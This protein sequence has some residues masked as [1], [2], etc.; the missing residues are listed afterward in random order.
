MNPSVFTGSKVEEDPHI[1]IYLI[2][3]ILKAMHATEIEGVDL[4]S[5]QLNDVVNIWF[6]LWEEGRDEDFDPAIWDDFEE[7]FLNHFFPQRG[8]RGEGSGRVC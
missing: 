1:F 5:Y 3:K 2:W 6:N 8:W 7:A 4:S